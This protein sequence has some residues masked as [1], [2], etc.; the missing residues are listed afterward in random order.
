MSHES[1]FHCLP[2]PQPNCFAVFWTISWTDPLFGTAEPPPP[3]SNRE[4]DFSL[5]QSIAPEIAFL[6]APTTAS[7]ANLPLPGIL[8]MSFFTRPE[9]GFSRPSPPPEPSNPVG[10]PL[11]LPWRIPRSGPPPTSKCAWL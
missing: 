2:E 8:S 1:A 4:A 11:Y 10:G 5:N 9:N 7:L 3:K 6:P